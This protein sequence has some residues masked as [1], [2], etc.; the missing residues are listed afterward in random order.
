[1]FEENKTIFTVTVDSSSHRLRDIPKLLELGLRTSS[2]IDPPATH[3]I[4]EGRVNNTKGLLES[5]ANSKG[6]QSP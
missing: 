5:P 4:G 2:S 1:M 6:P 3:I